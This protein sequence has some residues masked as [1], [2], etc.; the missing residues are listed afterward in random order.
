MGLSAPHITTA[1]SAAAC[2]GGTPPSSPLRSPA[3][4]RPFGGH[5]RRVGLHHGV[6]LWVEEEGGGVAG[7]AALGRQHAVHGRLEHIVGNDLQDERPGAHTL[8]HGNASELE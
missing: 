3:H 4:R 8:K 2:S 6:R 1:C 5:K 7:A